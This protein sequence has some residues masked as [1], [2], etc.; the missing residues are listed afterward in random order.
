MVLLAPVLTSTGADCTATDPTDAASTGA[1]K[2][3]HS[4]DADRN[5][6]HSN[7]ADRC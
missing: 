2:N 1:H 7:S 6:A 3:T 4:T 5:G